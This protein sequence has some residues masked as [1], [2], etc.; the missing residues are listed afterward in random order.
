AVETD[1]TQPS[2]E[3]KSA[4]TGLFRG[5]CHDEQPHRGHSTHPPVGPLRCARSVKDR[6]LVRQ[7]W[8]GETIAPFARHPRP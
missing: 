2:S 7:G 4:I 3:K 5:S 1:E 8:V 6:A